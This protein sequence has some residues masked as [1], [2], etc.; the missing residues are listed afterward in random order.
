[1]ATTVL[2]S[3]EEL[4]GDAV[5]T[6]LYLTT[7]KE[8]TPQDSILSAR[9]VN[10]APGLDFLVIGRDVVGEGVTVQELTG[11]PDEDNNYIVIGKE[12]VPMLQADDELTGTYYSGPNGGVLVV[13]LI[14]LTEGTEDS[15]NWS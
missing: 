8:G 2:I 14:G 11:D 12:L 10:I 6:N 5:E 13:P 7:P 15:V 4:T 9:L 1:M 3:V